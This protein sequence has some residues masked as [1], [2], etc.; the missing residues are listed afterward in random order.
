MVL[1][2]LQERQLDA[3]KSGRRVNRDALR[4][5]EVAGTPHWVSEKK[6]FRRLRP[7]VHSSSALGKLKDLALDPVYDLTD[8]LYK[9]EKANTSASLMPRAK[10]VLDSVRHAHYSELFKEAQIRA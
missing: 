2:A 7:V 10:A 9:Y 8:V 4:P 3:A 6:K 5:Y 1:V